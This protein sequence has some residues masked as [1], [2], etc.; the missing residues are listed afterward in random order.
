LAATGKSD[1]V[2]QEIEAAPYR[3]Y[4][5]RPGEYARCGPGADFYQTDPLEA[6]E[7]VDVYLETEE[8]WLGIRP[9][10]NSFCWVQSDQVEVA[11]DESTGRVIDAKAVAW[12]GTHLGRAR[13]YRWQVRLDEGEE[14]TII[15]TAHREGPEG[16]DVWYR[17]VPPAGEFR[18]V[19]RS[20]L[21]ESPSDVQRA[22]SPSE[23]NRS[24]DL[25]AGPRQEDFAG[26]RQPL[27]SGTARETTAEPADARDEDAPVGSGLAAERSPRSFADLARSVLTAGRPDPP[28]GDRSGDADDADRAQIAEAGV[29]TAS[30]FPSKTGLRPTASPDLRPLHQEG[31]A[32]G[33][34]AAE[35]RGPV[36]QE[37]GDLTD[38]D[39]AVLRTE[40]SRAMANRASA[41]AVERLRQ[42]AAEIANRSTN[43]FE[44][45]R[46]A[47]LLKRVEQYQ[48]VASR[49]DYVTPVSASEMVEASSARSNDPAPAET[50]GRPNDR[51]IIVQTPGTQPR[52]GA[53]DRQG[54][55]VRVYSARTGAPPYAITD[56]AG[57][58]LSYVTPVPGMNLN[59]YLNQQ[60]GL[61]G[62]TAADTS[63][64]TPHIIAEQ[65]VRLRR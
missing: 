61:Y 32:N 40:L 17:I 51:G 45:G 53:F 2:A 64:E 38:A 16:D 60:V 59:R 36:S 22:N 46:A 50:A 12:I 8:G 62:R 4:V 15:G 23:P 7:A 56:A 39:V 57:R 24:G 25:A 30:T 5:A 13:K 65:V 6:G 1:A 55:L 54:W 47:I 27:K 42:R 58:T 37:L 14:I 48:L 19:H 31:I 43:M 29:Q 33:K 28:P 44:R 49:R 11:R 9:P 21:V 20:Q 35:S 34:A 3:A 52:S 26:E 63:V 18:W 10:E 41:S